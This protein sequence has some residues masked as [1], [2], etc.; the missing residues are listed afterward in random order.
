MQITEVQETA[1]A[2]VLTGS[3]WT[4]N[5]DTRASGGTEQFTTHVGDTCTLTFSGHSVFLV[6]RELYTFGPFSVTIDGVTLPNIFF[7]GC[8]ATL[9]GAGFFY[10]CLQL[11]VAGLTDGPHVLVLTCLAANVYPSGSGGVG[12]DVDS[13][14]VC[15]GPVEQNG[16]TGIVVTNGDSQS[17]AV[18][19]W[20]QDNNWPFRLTS[21]LG[22]QRRGAQ[23]VQ[24]SVGVLGVPGECLYCTSSTLLGGQYKMFSQVYNMKANYG[25]IMYGAN[26]MR[27]TFQQGGRCSDFI[28]HLRNCLNF[29]SV[30]FDP[31]QTRL[32][33]LTPPYINGFIL[34]DTTVAPFGLGNQPVG[35][36]EYRAAVKMTKLLGF[37]FP[38]VEV[39]DIYGLFAG[40]DELTY[41]NSL[42]AGPDFGLHPDDGGNGMFIEAVLEGFSRF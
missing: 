36:D 22:K 31:A 4:L 3:G 11:I 14:L 40:A 5:T 23:Q 9:A 27:A 35:I 32:V 17:A 34:L 15:T 18:G 30:V 33:V 21:Q 2:V 8:S 28:R 37:E 12:F 6:H 42:F 16:N 41:P 13:F 7:G 38:N 24:V 1:A 25:T 10:R 20:Q 39:V 26:D 29:H 19:C